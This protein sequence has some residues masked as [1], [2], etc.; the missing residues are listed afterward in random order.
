[1]TE[2]GECRQQNHTQE[3]PSTQTECDYLYCWIKKKSV[4]YAKTLEMQ[5]GRQKKE[6]EEESTRLVIYDES[7]IVLAAEKQTGGTP[8]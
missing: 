5:L 1:M 4:T 2:T 7:V 3:A 8:V 6:E